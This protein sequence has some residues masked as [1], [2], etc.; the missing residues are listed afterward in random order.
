MTRA[1]AGP[2]P[3]ACARRWR[4]CA[5]S[6]LYRAPGRSPHLAGRRRT[7][8]RRPRR[9]GASFGGGLFRRR[10]VGGLSG[11]QVMVPAGEV[12]PLLQAAAGGHDPRHGA[13]SAL[14][15]PRFLIHVRAR[16][17]P[18]GRGPRARVST[19]C[20]SSGHADDP[21]AG[22]SAS[23]TS[24][25]RAAMAAWRGWRKPRSAAPARSACGPKQDPPSCW[26][27]T[28]RQDLD[29]FERLKDT[30]I[31][32][33]LRLCA[34][35]RLS[36][37]GQGQAQAHRAMAGAQ[38]EGRGEGLR[39][40]RAADGKAA[41][42]EGGARL[43]GQAHQ[44]RFA[45]ARLMV[46]HRHDPHHGRTRGRRARGQTIAAPAVPASTSAPPMPFPRPT[47]S[48]P[49]AASPISPSSIRATSRPNSAW[50]WETASMAATIAWPPARGTSSQVP[51]MKRSSPRG[52]T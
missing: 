1:A 13:R 28:T 21:A 30:P 48:M 15:G 4:S 12:A 24:S 16:P 22:R 42:A 29:P 20:A 3:S 39:R 10:A 19:P 36:R 46:L 6:R 27:R 17:P 44:S 8:A 45:R 41:G 43:A 47:S 18:S 51:R 14:R 11:R 7:L 33:H 40:H 5:P 31:G 26:R 38:G 50:R 25:P 32:R 49:G 37:S 34:E 52:T 23:A 2:T 35:P 9:G